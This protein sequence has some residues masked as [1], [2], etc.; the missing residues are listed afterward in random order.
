MFHW[1][2]VLVLIAV[3]LSEIPHQEFS[4]KEGLVN[5]RE[6]YCLIRYAPKLVCPTGYQITL[7]KDWKQ[8]CVIYKNLLGLRCERGFSI[9]GETSMENNALIRYLSCVKFYTPTI[10]N[11]SC[12]KSD[13]LVDNTC[14]KKDYKGFMSKWVCYSGKAVVVD[15]KRTC[16]TENTLSYEDYEDVSETL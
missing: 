1:T 15:G 8:T 3:A 6:K 10:G 4:C 16:V 14:L 13:L 9:H 2:F 11:L 5:E 12:Q 7:T